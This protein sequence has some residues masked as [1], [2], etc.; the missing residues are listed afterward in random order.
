MNRFGLNFRGALVV[1]LGVSISFWFIQRCYGYFVLGE[2]HPINK[3]I[4]LVGG[5]PLLLSMVGIHESSVFEW[6]P[7]LLSM[8]TAFAIYIGLAAL[9]ALIAYKIIKAIGQRL[10]EA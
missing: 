2:D 7:V 9:S 4:Q 3:V 10:P 1:M 8:L 5:R 6:V